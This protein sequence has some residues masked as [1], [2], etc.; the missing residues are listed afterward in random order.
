MDF[1]TKQ[2]CRMTLQQ[3]IFRSRAGMPPIWLASAQEGFHNRPASTHLKKLCLFMISIWDT[4]FRAEGDADPQGNGH[5]MSYFA[6]FYYFTRFVTKHWLCPSI[7]RDSS[8]IGRLRGASSSPELRWNCS[9]DLKTRCL[10]SLGLLARLFASFP[11]ASS[12]V[13]VRAA[14]GCRAGGAREGCWRLS[15]HSPPR[16]QP[17]SS[18][19]GRLSSSVFA[20]ELAQRGLQA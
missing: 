5:H 17:P 20:Q 19:L 6:V 4:G 13:W 8:A 14:A 3:C 10:E 16:E 15:N 11:S 9:W 2:P 1:L 18:G 7:P 12:P